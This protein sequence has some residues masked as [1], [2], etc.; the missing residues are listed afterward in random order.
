MMRTTPDILEVD[1][2]HLEDVLCRVEQTLDAQDAELIRALA[3]S[4]RYVTGL[5][6]DK[7]I[8]LRRLRQLLFGASTEKAAA[9][10][11]R[12]IDKSDAPAPPDAPVDAAPVA[13]APAADEPNKNPNDDEQAA[14]GH[15][16]KGADA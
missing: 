9:V 8:S 3:Q 4:Y 7:N 5:V 11:G 13:S 1:D 12:M 15:G 2:K 16:R 10:L 14:P 6:E